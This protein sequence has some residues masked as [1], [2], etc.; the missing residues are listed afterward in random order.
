MSGRRGAARRRAVVK[1]LREHDD[2]VRVHAD[3]VLLR[4]V[5]RGL[6]DG[7][8]PEEPVDQPPRPRQPERLPLAPAP[9]L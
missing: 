9:L 7:H 2:A 1:K 5:Q 3:E 8:G 6:A 4:G